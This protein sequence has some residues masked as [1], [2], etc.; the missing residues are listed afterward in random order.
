MGNG[1]HFHMLMHYLQTAE[2]SFQGL[3]SLE[4]ELFAGSKQE[5]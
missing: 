4:P 1:E 5:H 3:A 2:S